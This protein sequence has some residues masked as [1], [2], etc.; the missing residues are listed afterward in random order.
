M[1]VGFEMTRATHESSHVGCGSDFQ[2]GDGRLGAKAESSEHAREQLS[3]CFRAGQTKQNPKVRED[4]ECDTDAGH[5][6]NGAL[7]DGGTWHD[8]I[9]ALESTAELVSRT[10]VEPVLPA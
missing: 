5:R 2:D 8:C 4:N 1:P 3:R 10:G 7:D 9:A 6:G